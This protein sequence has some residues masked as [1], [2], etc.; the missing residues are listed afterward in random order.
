MIL[1]E[2][3]ESQQTCRIKTDKVD[4]S[5]LQ[6]KSHYNQISGQTE[7]F[8]DSIELPW[9][10]FISNLAIL[11]DFSSLYNIA[12]Q[13]SPK[14]KELLEESAKFKQDLANL[15][16]KPG[17]SNEEVQSKLSSLGFKRNLTQEQK[18]NLTKL[19]KL[20]FGATFSVPGAGKTT[21]AIAFYMLHRKEGQRLI[22]IC[23]KNAFPA[24]EEQFKVCLGDK[25][26]IVKRLTN[27]VDQID[28][29]LASTENSVFLISYQQFI[30]VVNSLSKFF[31]Y[32]QA[33]LFIDES[34]RM[35]GG[36]RTDTGRQIQRVA[37]L[38]IG[39]LIMS[40]TPMPQGE[41]DLLPQYSFLFPND[42][43]V[44]ATT[45][46]DKIKKIYVRTTKNEL[47]DPELFPVKIFK[48]TIPFHEPQKNLYDLIRSE[49]LRQISGLGNNDKKLYRQLGKSYMRLLQV[50]SNPSLLLRSLSNFPDALREAI[51]YG[52]SNKL[53]YTALK[54]RQLAKEGKKVLI[55]SGFVENVESLTQM[56][57]DLG[58]RCIHGGVEAGSEEE[59]DTRERIVKDF[60]DDP[61]MFVLVA[62]PAACSEGISLHT[63]CHHAIYLDR[64]YN[65]AQF[66]QSMDRI[67]RLGLPKGTVTTIEIVHT[68]NSID[69]LVDLRLTDKV[70]RMSEVLED[71]SLKV[72]AVTVELDEDG[73][74]EEDAKQLLKHLKGK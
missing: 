11:V 69:D 9:H 45:V 47:L 42:G 43:S 74:D 67:H 46:K 53:Q 59:E 73:F 55:W 40:G 14:A 4:S 32:N 5:W 3:I 38:P 19:S 27:G 29:D 34:H 30:R 62:N 57:S 58:A 22:V 21:E 48:T 1:I 49:E 56:L 36:D 26:P 33:F 37:H 28:S 66:L 60:H 51:E 54:A 31:H 15:D 65:A 17:L 61:N 25:A 41:P 44:D 7:F 16:S 18:R 50:V 63:V 20:Q 70:R 10:S 35:K 12:L 6:I 52:P 68:P 72:E 2:Y 23:P 8:Q 39:K 71:P 24:W 64:N 13:F